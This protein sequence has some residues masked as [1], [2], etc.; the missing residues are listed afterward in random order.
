MNT[1]GKG[2]ICFPSALL[3]MLTGYLLGGLAWALFL[4]FVGYHVGLGFFYHNLLDVINRMYLNQVEAEAR[5]RSAIYKDISDDDFEASLDSSNWA[6]FKGVNDPIYRERRDA[7]AYF[8]LSPDADMRA[9]KRAYYAKMNTYHPDKGMMFL[10]GLR[11][12]DEMVHV[13]S[14]Q[15]YYQRAK[16]AIKLESR[17]Q[18]D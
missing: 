6:A 12:T 11:S 14:I 15:S 18:V 9:L 4:A 17:T 10:N 5:R 2:I 3:G 8:G 13:H 1:E 16:A 7:L